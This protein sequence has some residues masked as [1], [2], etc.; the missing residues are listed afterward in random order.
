MYGDINERSQVEYAKLDKSKPTAGL[1]QNS[2][3]CLILVHT[4]SE[5]LVA[6]NTT[7]GIQAIVSHVS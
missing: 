1:R 7:H 4:L 6:R 3:D 5:Y 2:P